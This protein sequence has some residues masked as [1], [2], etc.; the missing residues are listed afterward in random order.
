MRNG[1]IL[2]GHLNDDLNSLHLF[3]STLSDEET[4]YFDSLNTFG[5]N[6]DY[7]KK[8]QKDI[9]NLRREYAAKSRMSP[10]IRNQRKERPDATIG[11]KDAKNLDYLRGE[12]SGEVETLVRRS[13]WEDLARVKE[14]MLRSSGR[15]ADRERERRVAEEAEVRDSWYRTSRRFSDSRCEFKNIF[16]FRLFSQSFKGKEKY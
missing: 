5:D 7:I 11:S 8:L 2:V 16:F 10:N 3:H 15:E 6:E 9:G 12:K 4:K 14:R 13:F 1:T